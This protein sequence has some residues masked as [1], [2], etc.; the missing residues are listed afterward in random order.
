LGPKYTAT[1]M[2]ARCP[3]LTDAQKEALKQEQVQKQLQKQRP[4]LGLY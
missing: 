4:N 2:Q 1:A 3:D